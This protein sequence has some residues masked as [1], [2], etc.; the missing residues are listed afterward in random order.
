[1][2]AEGLDVHAQAHNVESILRTAHCLVMPAIIEA[3][4]QYIIQ[5]VVHA[6]PVQ[7]CLPAFSMD[8]LAALSLASPSCHVHLSACMLL[9]SSRSTAPEQGTIVRPA[10]SMPVPWPAAEVSNLMPAALRV[11]W[12]LRQC[13]ACCRFY[14]LGKDLDL[15]QLVHRAEAVIVQAVS[16]ARSYIDLGCHYLLHKDTM[17]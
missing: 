4:E 5:H 7:V 1:M 3:A 15:D 11:C 10:I 12:L 6:A 13:W 8:G 9:A 14:L 2:H 17:L 16:A